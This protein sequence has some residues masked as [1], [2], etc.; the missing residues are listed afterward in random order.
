M[1]YQQIQ[2]INCFKYHQ[3][4]LQT[5]TNL[6]SSISN[7]K[8]HRSTLSGTFILA[9]LASLSFA[10]PAEEFQGLNS[11][12]NERI[13]P[14]VRSPCVR[15]VE[16]VSSSLVHSVDAFLAKTVKVRR[17]KEIDS[18]SRAPALSPGRARNYKY[19][20]M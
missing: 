15:V 3:A 14:D 11:T 13:R 12:L 20:Q 10:A 9:T 7:L 18:F 4:L 16:R 6:L 1:S 8:M 5:A 2:T 17:G 19:K